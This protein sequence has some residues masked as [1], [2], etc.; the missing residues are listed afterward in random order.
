MKQVR[1][2]FYILLALAVLFATTTGCG[3][4]EKQT[5]KRIVRETELLLQEGDVVFRRGRGL[6]SRAVLV[7]DDHGIYSHTGIV[8]KDGPANWRIVHIVPGE[9]GPDGRTDI[10]KTEGLEMFFAPD[11]AL[12]GAVMR[13]P[14]P[15]IAKAAARD[16]K[17]LAAKELAFDHDYDLTDTTRMYCTELVYTVF[18]REGVDITQGRRTPLN[19]PGFSGDYILP[20]D[21]FRSPHFTP[22]YEF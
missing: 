5:R 6:A 4:G 7:A 3:D 18:M 14:C 22:I 11:K 9:R 1:F 8:V 12:R 13:V 21:I 10:I 15:G 19:L 2:D 20:S 17:R 16:A